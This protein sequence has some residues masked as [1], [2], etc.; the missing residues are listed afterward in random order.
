MAI[1]IGDVRGLFSLIWPW[2]AGVGLLPTCQCS[3]DINEWNMFVKHV[4]QNPH[5]TR[6]QN[7]HK[8]RIQRPGSLPAIPCKAW[9]PMKGRASPGYATEPFWVPELCLDTW[10]S[11]FHRCRTG[12]NKYAPGLSSTISFSE[13]VICNVEMYSVECRRTHKLPGRWKPSSPTS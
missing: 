10:N 1:E 11:N 7:V 4:S 2:V 9:E 6:P 12:I 13:C 3:G 5:K 8:A